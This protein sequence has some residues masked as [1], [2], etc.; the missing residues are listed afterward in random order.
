VR[1]N[2]LPAAVYYVSPGQVNF[3]VPAGVSGT[4]SVQVTRDGIASNTVT[5]PAV[6]NAPGL[7]SYVVAG[8]NY[9]AAIFANS[10]LVVGD[11]ALAGSATR[12]A[13][14]GDR[15][16]LYATGLQSSPAGVIIN[17]VAG[18]SGVTA[19]IG[20]ATATVE[21]AGLVAVGEYQI[22][23]VVPNLAPGEYPVVIRY[24]GQSSQGGVVVP[25]TQ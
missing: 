8:K 6:A 23:I 2:N 4:A 14:V 9:P 20:T 11:P 7:F 15:I 19:T 16:Q 24:N 12:K 5:G 25:I 3:Q 10:F 17:S 22:N 21:F 13:V 1:V 18:V